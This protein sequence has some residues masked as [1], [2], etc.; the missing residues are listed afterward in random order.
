MM[1]RYRQTG[2]LCEYDW[3][4]Y[5]KWANMMEMEEYRKLYRDTKKSKLIDFM[6]KTYDIWKRGDYLGIGRY[7]EM[8]S[9]IVWVPSPCDLCKER[10][11]ERRAKQRKVEGELMHRIGIVQFTS[12]YDSIEV[13]KDSI[14]G[15][16]NRVRVLNRDLM[17]MTGG[18]IFGRY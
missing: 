7:K 8:V 11:K 16:F 2:F 18:S 13:A 5:S 10:V 17:L 14:W 15:L 3:L 9:G 12:E 1:Q 6:F 4:V